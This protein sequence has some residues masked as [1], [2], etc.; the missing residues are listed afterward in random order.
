MVHARSAKGRWSPVVAVGVVL[1][2]TSA[3]HGQ[4]KPIGQTAKATTVAGTQQPYAQPPPVVV[5][6]GGSGRGDEPT[7]DETRRADQ[8]AA[9]GHS[10]VVI[11]EVL[12]GLAVLQW[13]AMLWQANET[14][15]S[16]SAAKEAAQAAFKNAQAVI[17]AERPH[18]IFSD[19]I[20]L[21]GLKDNFVESAPDRRYEGKEGLRHLMGTYHFVNCGKTPCQIESNAHW[22]VVGTLPNVPDYEPLDKIPG[23]WI[24][25]ENPL[26][27]A[28][29]PRPRSLTA[30][31]R[32]EILNG[33]T[34]L[35]VIGRIEYKSVF[36]DKHRIRFAYRYYPELK[37]LWFP[38]DAPAYW[39]YT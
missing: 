6:I 2:L 22:F 35:H 23:V 38:E 14:R 10:L 5:N 19:D 17:D 7:P 3:H 31:Q 15:R 8:Q 32:A 1:S 37:D 21:L 13:I 29:E 28:A 39:E 18:L 4:A 33:K 20:E 12:A 27:C 30:T 11:T 34:P 36:G 25:P 9:D 16:A 24:A 26:T